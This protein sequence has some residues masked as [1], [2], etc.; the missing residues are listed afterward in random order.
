MKYVIITPAYNEQKYIAMTIDSVIA[1]TV[2][3][4]LWVIVDDGS[5]DRTAKIVRSYTQQY[6]I[7]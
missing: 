4:V 6:E 5:T 1:Q 7:A 2:K 3:P